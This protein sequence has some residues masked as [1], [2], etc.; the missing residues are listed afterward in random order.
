MRAPLRWIREFVEVSATADEVADRLTMAGTEVGSIVRIG[1]EWDQVVIGRIDEIGKHEG[2]DNLFVARVDVGSEHLTLVTAASNVVQG[3]VVPVVRVGGSLAKGH[4]IEARRFRGIRSEGMLC[5]GAELGISADADTIYVLEPEAPIGVDLSAYLGDDVL[6]IELTPNRPDCLG[7]LGI[8]REVAALTGAR[9]RGFADDWSSVKSSLESG[10]ALTILVDDGHLCPRY[11]AVHVAGLRVAPSPQWLQRRLFQCGMRPINNIVDVTNYV[12]LELGQPLHAFDA[13]TIRDATIRVRRARDGEILV[14]IDGIERE[15]S[16]EALVIADATDPIA[17]AGIMG[18]ALSEISAATSRVVIESATF[19]PKNVRRTSRRLRLATEASR[20]FD[21]GLDVELPA[22]ASRRAVSL[23]GQLVPG[24]TPGQLID[25]RQG[26]PEARAIQFSLSDLS[27]LIGQSYSEEQ[28]LGVLDSLGFVVSPGDGS[29]QALVPSWRGDVE[30]KADLAE[31]VARVVG[32]DAVPTRLPDGALPPPA[33][34]EFLRWDDDLRTRLA[35]AGLQEVMT[36]SLVDPY[37]LS[38]LDA[39]AVFPPPTPDEGLIPVANPMNIDQ[40]RLRSTLLPSLLNT[41]ASNLR[42]QER[43]ALFESARVFLPPLDPLPLEERRLAIALAGRRSPT[44]WNTGKESFDFYDLSAAVEA[45]FHALHVPCSVVAAAAAPWVHPGR[46]GVA[47]I[48]GAPE[49][50]AFLGQVHPRVAERFGIDN[51]EVYAA[52]IS[53]EL[54]VQRAREVPVVSPIP[55]YPAVERDLAL[56]VGEQ[57]SHEQ[58]SGAIR[59]AAGGL[60]E[61]VELFDVYQGSPIPAGHVSL[62][63]ALS[64]R[65]PSRT[66]ADEEVANAVE[67]IEREVKA[68]FGATIRGR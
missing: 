6:D 15:L 44:S 2:A 5:S 24:S 17:L 38:R 25:L 23:I 45:V 32:Y 36:Y 54:L 28:V 49:N 41:V 35:G 56:L 58:L 29:F 22:R 59:T 53:L 67:M 48:P 66:L 31:E 46:A 63:F 16:S 60:L 55:R 57:V 26:P 47:R 43:V 4:P 50:L 14:T 39:A 42:F 10:A 19:D 37:A 1:S 9:L 11:T 65:S 20:R 27:S 18:G 33:E 8:A 21:K 51:V 64:F 13:D 61:R 62:A 30:G 3:A 40:S 7:I 12:M 34:D 52:E 68:R